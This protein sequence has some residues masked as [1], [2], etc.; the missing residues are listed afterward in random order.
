MHMLEAVETVFGGRNL[1]SSA[2]V[3]EACFDYYA[4]EMEL[5]FYD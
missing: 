1:Y 2:I 4:I 5:D 3:L